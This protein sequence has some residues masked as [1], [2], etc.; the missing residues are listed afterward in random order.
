M[1][2]P[3]CVCMPTRS[4]RERLVPYLS[5]SGAPLQSAFRVGKIIGGRLYVHRSALEFLPE[6]VQ[7]LIRERHAVLGHPPY[8]LVKWAPNRDPAKDS[9]AFTETVGW[10]D[11][12]EPLM[13]MQRSVNGLGEPGRE[14]DYWP[15]QVIYHHKHLFV[16][17][18]YPG[19]G[20]GG[21]AKSEARSKV[22]QRYVDENRPALDAAVGGKSFM[23]KIGF[24]PVWR[25]FV[26]DVLFPEDGPLYDRYLGSRRRRR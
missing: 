10:D 21:Y 14:V 3:K 11:L 5:A 6:P 17:P 26:V 7:T 13:G 19:F 4:R 9:V 24:Y 16:H 25:E 22:W 8:D 15:R 18:G 12:P 20:T 2:K 1:R 23:S